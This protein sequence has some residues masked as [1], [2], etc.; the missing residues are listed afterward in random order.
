MSE[1]AA[2]GTEGDGGP[3]PEAG[4]EEEEAEAPAATLPSHE[5]YSLKIFSVVKAQQSQ[6][7]LRHNDHLRYRQY[8]SRRQR[9]LHNTLRFKHGRG[10]FKQV[11]FP[12]D[13]QDM[14]FL[15]IPLVNAERA[16]SYGVQL[17][18]DNATASQHNPRWRL[19]S[20]GRFSKAVNWAQ[21]LESVCKV[22][23][24]ARTQLEAEAYEAFLSGTY[25]LEKEEWSEALAKFM[26]CRRICEHLGLASGQESALFKEKAQELA[27]PIR[28]CRYN[29]GMG[30]DEDDQD[31]GLAKTPTGRKG[32][33]SELSYRGL[34]VTAP[35]EKIKGQLSKCLQLISA[36]K[37]E[38]G[39]E[40]SAVIEKYG[41]LSGEFND[42][43][44][45]IHADMIAAGADGQ[46]DEWRTLEA[47]ARELSICMNVERNLVLLWNHLARLDGLEEVCSQDSRKKCRP[48]EGMRFCDLL[49]EDVQGLL[50]LPHTT[51]SISKTLAG[52]VT[53]V[54]NCRCLFLALCHTVMGKTLEAASLMDMLRARVEDANITL[55]ALPEPLGRLHLLFERVQQ[56]MP[57][58]VSR[59]RCRGL[60]NMVTE[61]GAPAAQKP[62]EDFAVLAAFPPKVRD[63]P[64]KPLLFDLAFPCIPEPD[65][66]DLLPSKGGGAEG[67]QQGLLGRVAGGL[68]SRLGSLLGRK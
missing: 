20:I 16:W 68:G 55:P 29:L 34:D 60:V 7:G 6:N 21:M 62:L 19:H 15:E 5:P 56:G 46:T 36:I 14:R 44:K 18:A 13:F 66:E 8:C 28:E 51:E 17:K 37:A 24:D 53:V 11:P 10:R 64:C 25:L 41:E 12:A 32:D 47:F 30:Y 26:R 58:R 61:A 59:W 4:G 48:E 33:L 65:L 52:Y 42:T 43:L 38:P 49:K 1:E 35:S 67:Q 45:D 50:D 23:A 31:E 57:S 40:S 2:S 54:L 3:S 27:P 39:E 9:R 22:H 63:I